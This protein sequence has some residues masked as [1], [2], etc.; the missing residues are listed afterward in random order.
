[1]SNEEDRVKYPAV[2]QAWLNRR[3][4]KMGPNGSEPSNAEI[5]KVVKTGFCEMKTALRTTDCGS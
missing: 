5:M 3:R 1:M 4:D 2:P